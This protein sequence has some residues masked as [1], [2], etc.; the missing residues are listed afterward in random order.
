MN[1]EKELI[2]SLL[3]LQIRWHP[4]R[5]RHIGSTGASHGY[6]EFFEFP[7]CSIKVK[8][9]LATSGSDPHADQ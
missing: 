3:G 7:C 1:T 5:A 9:F 6:A 8:D 4:Q 2:R